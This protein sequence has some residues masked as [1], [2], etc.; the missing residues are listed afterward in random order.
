MQD[1]EL[2]QAI[3]DIMDKKLDERLSPIHTRL[4]NVDSQIGNINTRLDNVDSQIGNI[5]TRLDNVDSQIGNINTRLD[6]MDSQIGNINTRLDNMDSQ[7]GNIN[8]RLEK[9]EADT[10]ALKAGQNRIVEKQRELRQDIKKLDD[11]VTNTYDLALDAWGTST[12]NRNWLENDKL[13]A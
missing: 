12:E 7:I 3:S 11:K 5:N 4:D 1:N 9:L 6:N 13:K 2:L 10:S 8:T